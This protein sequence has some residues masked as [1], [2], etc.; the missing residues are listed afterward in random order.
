VFD[1]LL[2]IPIH[3]LIVHVTVVVVPTAAIAVLLYAVWPRFR[4]WAGWG[5]LALSVTAAVLAPLTTSSGESLEH[6]VGDSRLVEQHAELG[7]ML[8]WWVVPLA[9]L[10]A[11]LYWWHRGRGGARTRSALRVVMAVLPVLVA[12]GTL[13][14]VVLIG[15]SGAEA[16]WHDAGAVTGSQNGSQSGSGDA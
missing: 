5:P 13:V 16:A 14:Q 3:P 1:T 8:V 6:R 7:G 12:V 2:G 11:L 9:A 10:A 4:R 15:H